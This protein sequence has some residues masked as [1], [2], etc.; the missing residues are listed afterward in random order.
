MKIS[1]TMLAAGAITTVAAGSIIG[2]SVASAQSGDGGSGIVDRL[3]ERFSLNR[4]EVEAVFEEERDEKHAEMEVREEE[5]IAG[6]VEDGTLTQE[7]ADALN[8]KRDEMRQ[9][10]EDLMDQDLSFEEMRDQMRS[11]MEEFEA[12]AEEQGIDLDA[13]RPE[14][15]RGFG[16]HGHRMG[17]FDGEKEDAS[18]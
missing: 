1:K 2:T 12:W 8:A 7:Q 15:G 16:G 3:V 18:D 13:I 17:F 9:S 5:R 14:K 10:K 6:L 11:D 4:D